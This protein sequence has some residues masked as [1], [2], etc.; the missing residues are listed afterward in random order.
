MDTT[1]LRADLDIQATL[2]GHPLHFKSHHGLFSPK[3]ID[4]GTR[5]LLDHF[6]VEP[7][8]DNFD[9]GC[10]YG[11]LGLTLATDAPAGRTLMVDRDFLAVDYANRN[12]QLNSIT[13]AT[14][15]LGNGFD[16]LPPDQTFDNVVSNLPAKTGGELLTVLLHDAH[17]RLR[18]GGRLCVV[19]VTGLRKFIQRHMSDRFGNYDKLKQGK[20]HTVALAVKKP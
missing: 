7:H 4:E 12:A 18:P 8:H 20:T 19:T 5:L 15:Q 6:H 17:T 3:R 2:H 13:N 16:G 14:A 9:L 11:P 1:N 10:G